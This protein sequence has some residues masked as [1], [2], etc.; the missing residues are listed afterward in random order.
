[1]VFSD[2]RRKGEIMKTCL[3]LDEEINLSKQKK[4]VWDLTRLYKNLAGIDGLE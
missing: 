4:L 2:K 1:L 3:N